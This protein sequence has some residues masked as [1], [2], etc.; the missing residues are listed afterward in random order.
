MTKPRGKIIRSNEPKPAHFPI[1]EPDI[2]IAAWCP[3]P[4][5]QASPEEVHFIIKLGDGMPPLVMRFKSPDS[6][7]FFIEELARY[8]YYVWPDAESLSLYE[9]VND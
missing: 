8:R 4:D 2:E 9:Q 7:G 3:D 1:L 6:L 5:A